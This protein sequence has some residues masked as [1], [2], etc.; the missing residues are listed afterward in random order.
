[1]LC[2]E[3]VRIRIQT[4]K[5]SMWLLSSS[6]VD[7]FQFLNS[8]CFAMLL[9]SVEQCPTIFDRSTAVSQPSSV[10][11]GLNSSS[12]YLIGSSVSHTRLG[13]QAS[14]IYLFVF[15]SHNTLLALSST[16]FPFAVA[17]ETRVVF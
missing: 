10:R 3:V 17:G 2:V 15:C 13:V 7:T 14:Y 16:P 1:M 9:T 4:T 8:V 12:S 6:K 5:M 11:R